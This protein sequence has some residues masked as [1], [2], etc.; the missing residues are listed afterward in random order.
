MKRK[1]ENCNT[2]CLA[3]S[4]QYTL[5]IGQTPP[6]RVVYWNSVFVLQH[7]HSMLGCMSRVDALKSLI[8]HL[9]DR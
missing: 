1:I 5:F 2:V 9:I 4:Q 8:R 7:G 6:W 3:V